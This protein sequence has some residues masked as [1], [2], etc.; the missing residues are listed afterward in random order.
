MGKAQRVR[1]NFFVRVKYNGNRQSRLAL[2]RM[3]LE[4]LRAPK[5]IR[6]HGSLPD[7]WH[8]SHVGTCLWQYVGACLWHVKPAVSAI[9]GRLDIAKRCPCINLTHPQNAGSATRHNQN[10]HIEGRPRHAATLQGEN[11]CVKSEGVADG[12]VEGHGFPEVGEVVVAFF[13]GV[14]GGVEAYAEV[15]TE[16]EHADVEAEA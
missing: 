2:P 5:A 11:V 14:V 3:G 1:G 13:A 4:A 6:A 7:I 16:D 10:A 8:M 15:A 9:R 12:E